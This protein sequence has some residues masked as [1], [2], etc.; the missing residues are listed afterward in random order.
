MTTEVLR[1]DVARFRAYLRFDNPI[2]DDA[3]DAALTEELRNLRQWPTPWGLYG[4][5][6]DAALALFKEFGVDRF[7]EVPAD[8]M[9][10]LGTADDLLIAFSADLEARRAAVAIVAEGGR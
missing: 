3:S 5:V 4:Q 6:C 10:N 1:A 8:T 9:Y 2:P 7:A